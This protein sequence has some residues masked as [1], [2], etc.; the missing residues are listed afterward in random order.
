[1]VTDFCMVI[2]GLRFTLEAGLLADA[3]DMDGAGNTHPG[4]H[5]SGNTKAHQRRK[6]LFCDTF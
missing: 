1:M 6:I 4:Q 5:G 3:Y 2:G